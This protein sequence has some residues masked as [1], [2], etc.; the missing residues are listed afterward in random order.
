MEDKF[1]FLT[2]NSLKRKIKNKWFLVGNIIVALVI[3]GLINVDTIITKFGGD[4]ENKTEIRV[5]DNAGIYDLLN[6]TS[7]DLQVENVNY[8]LETKSVKESKKLIKNT[9]NILLIIN[10]DADNIINVEFISEKYIDGILFENISKTI[11]TSKTFVALNNLNISDKQLATINKPVEIDRQFIDKSKTNEKE[12]ANFI[13]KATSAIFVLPFFIAIIFLIQMIGA[14]VNEEK[15]TR[16]MEIIIGNVSPKVHFF[17]KI[18]ASNIFVIFQIIIMFA[19]SSMGLLVRKLTSGD[20]VVEKISAGFNVKAIINILKESDVM[21]RL[22]YVIPLVIILIVLSFLA[23][24]LLAGILASMT[25]N[26]ENYQQ[27]QT[28]IVIVSLIGY[29]L[30]AL[31]P[32]FK[33]AVFIKIISVIPFIS[34]SLA[35]AL[36]ITN[37]INVVTMITAIIFLIITNYILIKYGL[38]IYKQ[39]ILNY[40]E[41]GL[42]KKMLRALKSND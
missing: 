26:M 22:N 28:P 23:Y 35:P 6:K 30:I 33:G 18:L 16:S 8:I 25:T 7:N 40:S 37:D 9:D 10:K 13:L 31:A 4:F 15:S 14:E 11:N 38:K 32:L 17:S 39:G 29:Y 36:L 41:T 5:I 1:K 20:T 42:W 27:L 3:V 24:S 12:T 21:E 19:Y 34:L 2:K